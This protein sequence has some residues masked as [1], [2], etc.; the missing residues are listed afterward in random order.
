MVVVKRSFLELTGSHL[1]KYICSFST[2]SST[3]TFRDMWMTQHRFLTGQLSFPSPNRQHWSQQWNFTYWRHPFCCTHW[4]VY[5]KQGP[6]VWRQ[7]SAKKWRHQLHT[8]TQLFKSRWSGTTRIGRYE[9]KLTH[10]HPSWSSDILYQLFP[11][12][13][14]HSIVCVQFTCLTVLCDNLSPGPLWSSSWSWTL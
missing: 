5:S 14:I 13:T 1:V 10:S 2:C 8:H 3:K 12:T 6:E 9:K 7:Y 4:Q 11:F